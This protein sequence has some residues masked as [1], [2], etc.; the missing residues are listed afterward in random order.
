MQNAYPD[1]RARDFEFHVGNPPQCLPGSRCCRDGARGM[2]ERLLNTVGS[3][4]G[5]DHAA[6]ADVAAK[7]LRLVVNDTLLL[8]A[9]G[10]AIDVVFKERK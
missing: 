7:Y 4:I 9:A 1:V 6:H 3:W 2:P 8:L 5:D 10:I